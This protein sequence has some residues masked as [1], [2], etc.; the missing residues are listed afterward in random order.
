MSLPGCDM[1]VN[2][3][4]IGEALL[5][6][7]RDLRKHFVPMLAAVADHRA[8]EYRRLMCVLMFDLRRGDVELL[9]ERRKERIQPTAL[10]LQR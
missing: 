9:M 3:L 1:V 5:D 4:E 8:G 2:D 10:F 6:P 7:V